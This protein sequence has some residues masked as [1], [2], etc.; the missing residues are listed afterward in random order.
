M[1]FLGCSLVRIGRSDLAQT[2][3][4][5]AGQGPW[6]GCAVSRPAA[7]GQALPPQPGMLQPGAGYP[8]QAPP[9][10]YPPQVPPPA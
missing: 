3:F 9:T 7:P 2:W 1:G 5:R 4:Q 6:S 10:A 8:Q